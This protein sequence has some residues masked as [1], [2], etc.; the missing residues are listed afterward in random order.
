MRFPY[1]V[2]AGE[3]RAQKHDQAQAED[4]S[5][6]PGLDSI[7]ECGLLEGRDWTLAT[8]ESLLA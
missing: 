6:H 7:G 8:V 1:N 2:L 3:Y 4:R 5:T